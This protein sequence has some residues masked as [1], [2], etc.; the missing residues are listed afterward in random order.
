MKTTIDKSLNFN[1]FLIIFYSCFS[2]IGNKINSNIF[3]IFF[4]SFFILL[5]FITILFV[6]KDK[7]RINTFLLN[8]VFDVFNLFLTLGAEYYIITII[9]FLPYFAISKITLFF[10]I[11]GF[12]LLIFIFLPILLGFKE[13]SESR[14]TRLYLLAV[15]SLIISI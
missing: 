1:Y 9:L 3:D 11:I 8:D 7:K 2:I 12:Y 10:I 4:S 15:F 14:V 13:T 6:I 5:Y